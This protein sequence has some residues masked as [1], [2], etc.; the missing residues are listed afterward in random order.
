[1]TSDDFFVNHADPKQKSDVI[2]LDGL[3][4]FEQTS[5]DFCCSQAHSHDDTIWL[6]DD[7]HPNDIFSAHPDQRV[8]CRSRERHG[9]PGKAWHG[10]VFKVVFAIQ[11]SLPTS[12]TAR[13]S[14]RENPQTVVIRR[15]P[16]EFAPPSAISSG[17]HA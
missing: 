14:A 13:S 15:R 17:S 5:R 8:A 11:T 1:M 4:T 9:I 12:A 6:I 16:R 3:H 7:V 2:F 10:D